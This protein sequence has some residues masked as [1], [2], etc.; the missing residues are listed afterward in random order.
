MDGGMPFIT[1]VRSVRV[2]V[3]MC[4]LQRSEGPSLRMM[5]ETEGDGLLGKIRRDT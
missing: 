3:G 5:N 1:R 4:F 2:I